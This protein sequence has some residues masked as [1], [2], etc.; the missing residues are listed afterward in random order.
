[1]IVTLAL[2]SLAARPVR[3]AVLAGGF[4]LGVA[5][6]VA[7][8]GIGSVILDQAR[9]PA[10]VGGG[11]VVV[12]AATGR[13]ANARFFAASVLGAGPLAPRVR[14][15][16]PSIH[17]TVYVVGDGEPLPVRVT[18]GVPSRERGLG[19]PEIAQVPSWADTP[20]DR[21]WIAPDPGDLLRAMDRFHPIPAVPARVGSWA[22]WLYFNGRTDDVRFYLTFLAGPAQPS[23]R[24]ELGV[25]LQL[26]RA[27]SMTSYSAAAEVDDADLVSSAPDLT[28]GNNRVRLSGHAY[29][30]SLDLPAERSRERASGE[31]TFDAEPGRSLPPFELH[32]AGGWVSGYTV[33]VM[34]GALRG[35][36]RVG[37]DVIHLDGGKGYHDH[38]WGFWQGVSWQ[39]GQVHGNG[40]SFVY[41][42]VFPPRDAADPSR[43]PGFLVALGPDGPIGFAA[44]VTIEEE[45]DAATGRPRRITVTGASETL[46]LTLAL[47]VG[48]TTTT[49]MSGAAFGGG[50]DFLQMRAT[51]HVT[52]RAGETAVDFSTVGSAETFRGR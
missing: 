27:G 40:L 28:A 39:W 49:R 18:G 21:S 19:D 15:A 52:G 1:V 16:S 3:S 26:E 50:L 38:N 32:G 13:L 41:G 25:R 48:Q 29:T 34:S 14:A 22:E 7:L 30:I 5:V 43:V 6:M 45:N 12:G 42:R 51:Y 24:R 31:I 33:P 37:A 4:G 11:D 47:D 2:R 9:A 36:L 23:G 8:L 46:A 17:D 20:A 44:D 10:L 35:V